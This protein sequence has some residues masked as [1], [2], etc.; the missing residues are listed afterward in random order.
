MKTTVVINDR[1]LADAKV[2]AVRQGTRLT[3]LVEEGLQ[4]RLRSAAR[5]ATAPKPRV[6]VLNAR[7]LG[8]RREPP[9]QQGRA[10]RAGR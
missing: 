9:E 6:P 7:R 1:L 3:R 5:P 8:G 4:L 10:R 2:L